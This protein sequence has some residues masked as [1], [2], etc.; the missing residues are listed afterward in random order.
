MEKVV[1][2]VNVARIPAMP[3][4]M[5]PFRGTWLSMRVTRLRA[6]KR[7]VGK[8]GKE[9]DSTRRCWRCGTD[10]PKNFLGMT[11]KE[12]GKWHI[13][14][15][16]ISEGNDFRMAATTFFISGAPAPQISIL[17][18][19]LGYSSAETIFSSSS[20]VLVERKKNE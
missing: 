5:Y 6:D 17:C 16:R 4:G 19:R 10:P 11:G 7:S 3:S 20:G 13:R 14:S 9:I 18:T 15:R 12:S 8:C 2:L 1:R